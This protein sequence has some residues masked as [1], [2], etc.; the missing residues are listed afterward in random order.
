MKQ[1]HKQQKQTTHNINTKQMRNKNTNT[2]GTKHNNDRKTQQNTTKTQQ[3]QQ[4]KEQKPI[5]LLQIHCLAVQH[6]TQPHENQ[7]QGLI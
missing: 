6:Q 1:Q 2:N 3:K 5:L 7:Q 4:K